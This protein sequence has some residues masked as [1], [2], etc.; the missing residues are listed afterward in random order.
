VL[1]TATDPE[2]LPADDP[3]VLAHQNA[4]LEELGIPSDHKIKE[5]EE[6]Y[7]RGFEEVRRLVYLERPKGGALPTLVTYAAT[8]GNVTS[9]A[10]L[11]EKRAA[12]EKKKLTATP[13]ETEIDAKLA[14]MLGVTSEDIDPSAKLSLKEKKEHEK[15]L[16][17]IQKRKVVKVAGG[18]ALMWRRH[19]FVSAAL[20]LIGQPKVWVAGQR[21]TAYQDLIREILEPQIYGHETC[22]DKVDDERT[23]RLKLLEKRLALSRGLQG[24]RKAGMAAALTGAGALAGAEASFFT[25]SPHERAVI[26]GTLAIFGIIRPARRY[27]KSLNAP[28]SF[29]NIPKPKTLPGQLNQERTI[30]S[31]FRRIA[32][33]W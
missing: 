32:R 20:P 28:Q 10:L 27:I 6:Y 13:A 24:M 29:Q 1:A 5:G 21:Q 11:S 22:M 23:L 15:R 19:R 25:E 12:I 3:Y 8:E 17:Y 2:L 14:G 33:K 9:V 7:R 31:G 26:G 4:M 16:K 18:L 30:A